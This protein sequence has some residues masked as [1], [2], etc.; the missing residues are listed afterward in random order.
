MWSQLPP[1][2]PPDPLQAPPS[3]AVLRHEIVGFRRAP[4]ARPVS[5][6]ITWL[7]TPRREQRTNEGPRRLDKVV[8]GEEGRV[9]E[10]GVEEQRL[11]RL[12]HFP[13]K[14]RPVSERHP[15]PGDL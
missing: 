2:G 10:H 8:P 12:R 14:R 1:R 3:P 9:A 15:H 4:P 6:D 11:I 13:A 7:R 5:W